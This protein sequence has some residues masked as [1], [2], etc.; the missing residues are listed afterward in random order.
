MNQVV[1]YLHVYALCLVRPR[2]ILD[3]LRHGVLPYVDGD[4]QLPRPEITG[5]L[6]ISWM[7][8]IVQGIV[9]VILANLIVQLFIHYHNEELF[10]FTLVDVADGLFPY[11][12]LLFTT[13]LDLV[14]F[15]ILTLIVTEFWNFV[16]RHYAYWLDVPGDHDDISRQITTVAL[17][18]HF[19]LVLPVIGVVFQQIAW[20]YLLYVGCRHQLGATRSLALVILITPTVLL[21]MGISL[22]VLTIFYL[23]MA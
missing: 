2:A 4:H 16:L 13:A 6:G 15:P 18:S 23:I 10:F 5:Q 3:W 17:S 8:A 11:Y 12:V 7:F 1:S 21:L 20:L 14:F 22:L 9:R 19:F